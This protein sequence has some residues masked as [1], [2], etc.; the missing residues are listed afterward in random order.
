MS[1]NLEKLRSLRQE[2][3]AKEQER[4]HLLE[5]RVVLIA[6]LS[7]IHEQML[8]DKS[9]SVHYLDKITE[10]LTLVRNPVVKEG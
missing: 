7:S 2:I 9:V 10:L 5:C 3:C 8:R 6:E 1:G 4:K